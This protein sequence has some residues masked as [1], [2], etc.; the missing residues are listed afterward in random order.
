MITLDR[1]VFLKSWMLLDTASNEIFLGQKV[2]E[3]MVLVENLLKM[4]IITV[5]IMIGLRE[6]VNIMK[7]KGI[8]KLN[9]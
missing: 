5:K 4:M 6:R 7:I 8:G 2:E 3:G 9:P 1:R